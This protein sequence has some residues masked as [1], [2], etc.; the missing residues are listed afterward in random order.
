MGNE[1]D[2]VKARRPWLRILALGLSFS[3]IIAAAGCRRERRYAGIPVSQQVQSLKN[4]LDRGMSHSAV[5]TYLESHGFEIQTDEDGSL[6]ARMDS[7][8]SWWTQINVGSVGGTI[9]VRVLFNEHDR[10]S[11]ARVEEVLTGP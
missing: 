1:G 7:D 11:E 8:R 3:V 2:S 4:S 5:R 10:L 9:R 6:S